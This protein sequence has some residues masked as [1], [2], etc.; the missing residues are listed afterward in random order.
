MVNTAT[1]MT[2]QLG[3][4]EETMDK[5][6]EVLSTLLADQFTL[7]LKLR[8]YHWNVTGPQF[9]ALHELFEQQYEKLAETIDTVAERLRSYG[10]VAP[11]TMIEFQEAARLSEQ[12]GHN[13]QAELMVRDLVSDHEALVRY[14]RN[15][16]DIA[17]D[18]D[19]DG[20]ED[21]LTAQLQEHQE[22][23]WMLRSFITT[24]GI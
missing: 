14:L 22:M 12:A 15:D 23:A 8:K 6:V 4:S 20:L 21:F 3:L 9:L 18:L 24:D 16:I 1:T 5:A 2:P 19:D 13:P 11:G 10:A 7:R 17:D